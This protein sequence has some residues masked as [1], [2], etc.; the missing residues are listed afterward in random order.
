MDIN[1]ILQESRECKGGFMMSTAYWMLIG[2]PVIIILLSFIVFFS[3]KPMADD[4]K[5]EHTS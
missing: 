1:T 2:L 3:A 4:E 5:K